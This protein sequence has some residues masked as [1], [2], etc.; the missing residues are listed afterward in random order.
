M[1]PRRSANFLTQRITKFALLLS[2]F[3][4][5]AG[6]LAR[7]QSPAPAP[8][9]ATFKLT[10]GGDVEKP[11]SLSLDDLKHSPR[12]TLKVMNPHE[13]K[14]ENYEGVPLAKI[15]EQAGVPHGSQLR[16]NSMTTVVI[17]EGADGYRAV[18]ALPELDSDFQEANIIV[19]DTL[20]GA[21]INDKLG[22]LRVVAPKDKR[23]ARWVRNLKS[24]TI[25]KL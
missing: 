13:N 16:G 19:A 23:P 5:V 21:P 6:A 7:A 15:L 12:T 20:D 8:S 24:I 4:A 22:P 14:E 3:L 18:F 9:A 10:V 17:A 2:L 11:L 25:K 1:T